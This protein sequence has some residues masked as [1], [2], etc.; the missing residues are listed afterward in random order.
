MILDQL[1]IFGDLLK[2]E[3][4][5]GNKNL[6]MN[7]IIPGVNSNNKLDVVD[8][9]KMIVFGNN[10]KPKIKQVK[11]EQAIEEALPGGEKV[12]VLDKKLHKNGRIASVDMVMDGTKITL[13]TGDKVSGVWRLEYNTAGDI[14]RSY[15]S[16][17][18]TLPQ[19]GKVK[20]ERVVCYDDKGNVLSAY[21]PEAVE[22]ELSNGQKIK[23]IEDISYHA[24]GMFKEVQV[25]EPVDLNLGGYV[26]H[27]T[28]IIKINSLGHIYEVF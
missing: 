28:Y 11:V 25:A 24:N 22:I 18:I 8:F 23:I 5:L 1:K 27:V 20:V 12:K 10:Y 6:N 4:G 2:C 7:K 19:I 21:L 13:P 26:H 3:S 16:Y 14:I 15:G 9:F 17:E